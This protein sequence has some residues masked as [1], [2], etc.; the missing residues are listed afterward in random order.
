MRARRSVLFVPG[1]RPER[2]D[3]A[4]ATGADCICIDLEDAVLPDDKARARIQSLTYLREHAADCERLLRI[5]PIATAAG[6]ADMQAIA[7]ALAA[8]VIIDGIMLAKA[9]SAADV[10]QLASYLGEH[11]VSL[12]PLIESPRGLLNADAIAGADPRVRALMFGA[13]DFSAELG[14]SM[15]WE[16]LL[17]ARGQLAVVAAAHGLELIDVPFV[18]IKDLQGLAQETQRVVAMGFSA[19]AAIHPTQVE[20]IHAQFTPSD[21][22]IVQAQKV[23]AA[24]NAAGGGAFLVDGKMV[25]RPI[26]LLAERTLALARA[27]HKL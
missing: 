19:K 25:D 3:K 26:V 1:S 4:V 23:V 10:R 17:F 20:V 2:F 18:Q 15:T 16:P 6:I 9:E 21:D 14:V 11:P 13:A 22:A 8:G 24:N 7:G 5:N 27:A 12:I